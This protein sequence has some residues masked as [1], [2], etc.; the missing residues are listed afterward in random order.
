MLLI[1]FTSAQLDT[2]PIWIDKIVM[3]TSDTTCPP[4]RRHQRQMSVVPLGVVSRPGS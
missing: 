2:S 3:S 1:T 4:P